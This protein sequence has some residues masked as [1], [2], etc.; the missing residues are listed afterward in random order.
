MTVINLIADSYN[1]HVPLK[2]LGPTFI[3]KAKRFKL[4]IDKFLNIIFL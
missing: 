1:R 4:L 3:I 2:P